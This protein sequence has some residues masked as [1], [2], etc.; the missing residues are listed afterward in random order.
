MLNMLEPSQLSCAGPR[1]RD[2]RRRRWQ[3]TACCT[4]WPAAAHSSRPSPSSPSSASVRAATSFI[5][6]VL[7]SARTTARRSRVVL[8]WLI[9]RGVRRERMAE[10]IDVFDVNLTDEQI[11]R[12]STLDTGAS[13]FFDTATLR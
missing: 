5:N 12:I 4:P 2:S 8:R 7:G 11:A 6:S 10:N 1:A 13:L 9:Q 3:L